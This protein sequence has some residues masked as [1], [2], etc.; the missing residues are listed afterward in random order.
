MN[1]LTLLSQAAPPFLPPWEKVSAKPAD[2]GA[3]SERA[4]SALPLHPPL[5]HRLPRGAKAAPAGGFR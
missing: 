3:L 4:R 2:E 1:G 5:G